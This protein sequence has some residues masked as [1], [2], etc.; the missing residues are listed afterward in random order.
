MHSR[1]RLWDALLEWRNDSVLFQE[2][3]FSEETQALSITLYGYQL[4]FL[5]V[6]RQPTPEGPNQQ[7][8]PRHQGG[9]GGESAAAMSEEHLL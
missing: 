2:R 4:P 9:P 7:E 3:M 1:L 8:R 5:I 6:L